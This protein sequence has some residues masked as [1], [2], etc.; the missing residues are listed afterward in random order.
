MFYNNLKAVC[1]KQG[2]K[3][4][5][6]VAECGGAKGSISNW[7]GGAS[8]NSDIVA[9]LSVRLNVSTDF[10]IFGEEKSP[11]LPKDEL[12]LLSYYKKLPRDEQLRLVSRAETLADVYAERAS[13]KP[14]ITMTTNINVY[15]VAAGAGVSVPFSENDNYTVRSFPQT[16]V[17]SNADCG[18]YINGKSMEPKFPDGCIVWVDR[19]REVNYGDPVIAIFDGAPY[20]KIYQPDGL[21]SINPDFK[22]I[23]VS[24]DDDCEIFGKVIGFYAE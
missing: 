23:K 11:S 7:K 19:K 17:P 22:T 14:E 24:D 15:V 10:L 3:I 6:L 13:A 16:D 4:T 5:P 18:I 1:D 8:P 21:H 2:I 12:E 9:K 20:C